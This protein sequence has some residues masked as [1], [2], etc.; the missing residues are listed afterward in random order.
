VVPGALLQVPQCRGV[1]GDQEA[2]RDFHEQ[3]SCCDGMPPHQRAGQQQVVHEGDNEEEMEF[4]NAK[5]VIKVVYGRSDSNFESSDNEHHKQLHPRQEQ[6]PTTS[7]L[8]CQSCLTPQTAPGTW[9][10]G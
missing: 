3:Q 8:R 5:R 2:H 6:C 4:Q 10:A 1:S 9:W 7:G